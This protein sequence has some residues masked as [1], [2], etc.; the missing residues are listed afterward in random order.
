MKIPSQHAPDTCRSPAKQSA[1]ALRRRHLPWLSPLGVAGRWLATPVD[2]DDAEERAAEQVAERV[3]GDTPPRPPSSHPPRLPGAPL[4]PVDAVRSS[5]DA[6]ESLPA[7]SREEFG[8]ALGA[9]LTDVRVHTGQRAAESASALGARAYTVGTDVAFAEGAYVPHTAEGERLLAHEL[10]HVVQQRTGPPRLQRQAAGEA[11]GDAPAAATPPVLVEDAAEPGPGQMRRTAFL[12]QL[13]TDLESEIA[14]AGVEIEPIDDL[15]WFTQ[16]QGMSAAELEAAIEHYTGAKGGDAT[17]LASA[18]RARVLGA[19]RIWLTTGMV[20]GIPTE[21]EGIE[22]PAAE[23]GEVLARAVGASKPGDRADAT[24]AR[25]ALVGGRA[26]EADVRARM[27]TRFGR[28][29]AHARIHTERRAAD[30]AA[31]RGVE[32]FALGS[33]IAFAP[34]MYQPGTSL[35]D[36]RLAHELVHTLQRRA[37]GASPTPALEEEAERLAGDVVH[38]RNTAV[39]RP[40]YGIEIRLLGRN[41]FRPPMRPPPG[42]QPGGGRGG[43]PRMGRPQQSGSC[44]KSQ[45][46]PPQPQPQQQPQPTPAPTVQRLPIPTTPGGM[47]TNEFGTRVMRWGSGHDAARARMQTLTR[48]ELEQAGVTRSMAQ[49]WRDFYRNEMVR[50]PNNPSAAGRAYLMQRAVELLQ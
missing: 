33:D 37:G 39:V 1:Q 15:P 31:A 28:S 32:A 26:L 4:V 5:L 2:G 41:G 20:V 12:T 13:R 47:S 27:E 8:A 50:N 17:A 24:A 46:A 35:G 29:L 49:Q 48:S 34:G 3:R 7:A 9:D 40:Q 14:A 38:G 16:V 36:H 23:G 25:Q 18:V 43:P 10:T 21:A 30:E 6:G 22:P 19:T 42:R 45:K 44:C 11:P